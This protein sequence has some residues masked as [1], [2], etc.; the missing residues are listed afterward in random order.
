MAKYFLTSESVTEGHPDKLADQISDAVLD[1]ILKQ[2]PYGRVAIESLLTTGQVII[3]GEVTTKAYVDAQSIVRKVLRDAGYVRS[4]YGI[5]ADSCGVLVS[6]HEQSIDIAHGIGRSRREK[7]ELIGAGDQGMMFG[8]ATDETPELMPAPIAFAHRVTRG[9]ARARKSREIPYLRPDGKSQVTVEYENPPQALRA[10]GSAVLKR[11]DTVLVSA[12]HAPEAPLSKIKKDIIEKVVKKVLPKN[13]IDR[14]TKFLVNPTGRFVIGGP[15]GDTGLTGRKIIVD[16]Y[17]GVGAHGGGAFS[18][19]DPT[20]V[21]RSASYYARYVAKNIVAAGLAKKVEVKVAYA[22][23]VP[24]P[25]M[26]DVD[27]FGTSNVGREKLARVVKKVFDFRPGMIIKEL[28][29]RRP[30]YR[31]V[32]AYGHFGRTDLDL[33]WEKTNKVR[34]LRRLLR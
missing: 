17:G 29:L 1:E 21:D 27:D 7:P 30:I 5:D 34:A 9:L 25:L 31:Q 24:D 19:K 22:I 33:P 11:I 2:D 12:Q 8:Y 14:R 6:I 16:T 20:K 23:G 15:A 4:D 26:V 13:L 3:A 28:R 10:G 32:A 18:G